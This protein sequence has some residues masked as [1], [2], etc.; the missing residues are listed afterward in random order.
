MSP[1]FAYLRLA[2]PR[3][4]RASGT[5]RIWVEALYRSIRAE[6][7]DY[8]ATSLAYTTLLTIVPGLAFCFS[9]LKTFGVN[10]HL[11]PFLLQLLA[12]LGDK[13][14]VLTENI[15][16]FVTRVNVGVLGFMGLLV[17]IHVS[18]SMLSKIEIAFNHIW[19][20]S[21]PRSLARRAGDYL[22]V[23]LLGPVLMFSAIGLTAS[24][25]GATAVRR[26]VAYEPFGTLFFLAGKL[27]SLLLIIAAFTFVYLYIPNTR[28]PWRAA[29]L[30]GTV[31]G[32]AWKLA[33]FLFAHFVTTSGSYHAIYSSLVIVILFMIWLDLSWLILLLGGQAAMYFQ[34]PYYLRGFE[35][36][37]E[38]GSRIREGLGLSLM[39]LI[40]Q[41]F[42]RNQ[43]PWSI[44][45]LAEHLSLP[46][47]TVK[48]ALVLLQQGGLLEAT[49][50]ADESY[51][52]AHDIA[53]ISVKDIITVMRTGQDDV[54]LAKTGPT[55][56]LPEIERIVADLERQAMECR[57]ATLSLRELALVGEAAPQ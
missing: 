34:H 42:V 57:E 29:L 19:R 12:P 45:A 23:I 17:L 32:L 43:P 40:A 14:P 7:L 55:H 54:A 30:G 35:R 26:L 16:D 51:V 18:V 37:Q 15:L 27:L 53:G 8:R 11:E 21:E 31:G 22:N 20:V 52:P 46:W 49:G 39:T 4:E 25:P 2:F 6:G 36:F 38:L 13:A 3:L 56:I 41:R 24:M 33:G 44:D 28:V 48:E 47:V 9:L 50:R 10:K 1:S 5:V